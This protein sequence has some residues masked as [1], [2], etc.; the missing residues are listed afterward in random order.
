MRSAHI[1]SPPRIFIID[2]NIA[3]CN[4]MST[5]LL[6][7]GYRVNFATDGQIEL[8]DILK[9]PPQC[10]IIN[11]ILP[12]MS[13]YAICRH[14]RTVYPHSQ[15]PII[16]VSSQYTSL[17]Q[18]YS[19]RVGANYY[20]AKPFTG[21]DL[22]QAVHKI[23]PDFY[24]SYPSPSSIHPSSGIQKPLHGVTTPHAEK[25]ILTEDIYTFIPYRQKEDDIFLNK[26]PF[27]RT[28]LIPDGKAR[29]IYAIIDGTR[30]IQELASIAQLDLVSILQIL[31]MLWKLQHIAFFD[32]N[33][34]PI[35]DMTLFEHIQ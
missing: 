29:Q 20:L 8:P 28:S 23:L 34:R 25:T 3:D 7:A 13:G 18:N 14:I 2:S 11:S 32:A 27:A 5:T 9:N 17:D 6:N 26:N 10:L 16:I 31:K 4:F 15:V 21:N 33:R 1:I 19:F 30:N 24:P 35:Q 22:L 12:V